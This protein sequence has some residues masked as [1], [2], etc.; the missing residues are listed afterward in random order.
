MTSFVNITYSNTH[1][2]VARAERAIEAVYS[3]V[4]R[5]QQESIFAVL[6]ALFGAL[7]LGASIYDIAQNSAQGQEMGAWVVLWA[8]ILM[9]IWGITQLAVKRVQTWIRADRENRMWAHAMC[10]HRQV[11]DLQWAK[12][13]KD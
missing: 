5:M 11:A 6:L 1:P 8:A 3:L 7:S 10:D 12:G 13:R 4:K 2:G 9:S